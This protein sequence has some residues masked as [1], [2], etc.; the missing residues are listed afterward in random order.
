[1][2]AAA[3]VAAFS[4]PAAEAVYLNADG[5]GQALIFPYYT[6]R[7]GRGG[8]FNTYLSVVNPTADV[9]ALRLRFREGRNGKSVGDV[10]LYLGPN[11]VWTA[12]MVPNGAGT[13]VLS[14]DRSCTDP[15]V[16]DGS[17]GRAVFALSNATFSGANDDGAGTGLDRTREG[18][19]EVLEMAV[20]SGGSAAA[21]KWSGLTSP[22]CVG[23]G[24]VPAGDTSVP[25]GGLSGSLTLINVADGSDYSVNATALDE[26]FTRPLWRPASD[27]YPALS[28]AEVS[29][30]STV[31][32]NGGAYRSEW[33]SGLD[34][35]NAALMADSFVTEYVLD[36]ATRSA[37]EFVM[38]FPTRPL[39]IGSG[40]AR[41]PF[42]SS[43]S[44]KANCGGIPAFDTKGERIFFTYFNREQA[45]VTAENGDLLG[46]GTW[47]TCSAVAVLPI[48]NA[49]T[50]A[51]LTGSAIGGTTLPSIRILSSFQ[52]GY[53]WTGF[54]GSSQSNQATSLATSLR[55]DIATGAA[56]QGTHTYRG[57]PLAGFM[58]RSLQNGTLN[59]SGTACQGNYGSAFPFRVMRS[60]T[61]N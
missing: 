27:G 12:A 46:L 3:V 4:A 23:L 15:L 36:A 33:S 54:L 26:V 35:V 8:T 53:L 49:D 31:V 58:L 30:V 20:L 42:N 40:G 60:V 39:S 44:W 57:L 16:G 34:A 28:A 5:Q 48:V 50:A 22:S 18:Y 21:T 9:K 24:A 37:T 38:T 17:A 14:I 47:A 52:N 6:V 1:M 11:D 59:C 10:N 13:T 7:D 56:K 43:A 29:P 61:A 2:L 32:A 51:T 41:P 19:V 25:T 45:G 55:L